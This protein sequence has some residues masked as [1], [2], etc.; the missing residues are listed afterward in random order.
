M[1]HG[2]Q[3]L[4]NSYLLLPMFVG[5]VFGLMASLIVIAVVNFSNMISIY[6]VTLMN[7]I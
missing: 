1:A 2:F 5:N 7:R 4:C 3:E 6:D